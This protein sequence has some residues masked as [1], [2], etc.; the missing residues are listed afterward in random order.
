[1]TYLGIMFD[2]EKHTYDD[3][4]LRIKSVHIG[5]PETK[6]SK[7]ELPGAD[8]YLD[9]TDYFGTR[10]E[11]REIEIECDIED[12]GYDNWVYVISQISNYLHGKKRKIVLDWDAC[13]YYVGRGACEYDK[14][15]RIYSNIVLRFDCEPYKY[16]ITA[17]DEDWLWDPFNLENGVIREYG[18]IAVS[19]NKT[20]TVI[21]SPMPVV[22]KFIASGAMTLTF[23]GEQYELKRGEN[24]FPDLE[25]KDGEHQLYFS[26]NGTVSIIYRG[27]SL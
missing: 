14:D 9:M 17:S 1:M 2:N 8:G 12:R 4:K 26:G 24:Y 3:F 13:F 5:M 16:E 27:G 11:N 19:G 10:Y 22:P 25:I 23:E 6:E 7:L 21:G 15:N 18:N 20:V